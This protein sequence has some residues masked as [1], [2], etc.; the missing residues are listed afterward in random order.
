MDV[1][2]IWKVELLREHVKAFFP[3]CFMGSV[4]AENLYIYIHIY[5]PTYIHYIHTYSPCIHTYIHTYIQPCV[6]TH[7]H[8]RTYID[9]YILTYIPGAETL[10]IRRFYAKIGED[11]ASSIALFE[12]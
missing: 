7:T 12:G 11:N 6:H 9:T 2:V 3:G 10:G 5:T 4:V 8:T 1:C